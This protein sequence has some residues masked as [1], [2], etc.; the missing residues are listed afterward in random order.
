M[1]RKEI[2]IM[3]IFT[4]K[5][6]QSVDLHFILHCSCLSLSRATIFVKLINIELIDFVL[7]I[8]LYNS[9]VLENQITLTQ[10]YID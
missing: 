6:R 8:V 9:E 3:R 7:V 4:S 10:G 5:L 1:G 2:I